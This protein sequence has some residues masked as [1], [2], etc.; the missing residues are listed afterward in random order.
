M[1]HTLS[2]AHP[3]SSQSRLFYIMRQAVA[4]QVQLQHRSFLVG[5]VAL[6]DPKKYVIFM[7]LCAYASVALVVSTLCFMCVRIRFINHGDL[8]RIVACVRSLGVVIVPPIVRH[9]GNNVHAT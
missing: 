3:E 8:V 2:N 6:F 1:H 4:A 9:R 7:R 5:P